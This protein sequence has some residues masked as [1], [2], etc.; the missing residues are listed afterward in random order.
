MLYVCTFLNHFPKSNQFFKLKKKKREKVIFPLT[1]TSAFKQKALNWAENHAKVVCYFDNNGYTEGSVASEF[2]GLLAI[3]TE[4]EIFNTSDASN[5]KRLQ[6]LHDD[7][8]NWLFGFL[9]YDLKNEIERLESTHFDGVHFP[10]MHF[11]EPQILLKISSKSVEFLKNTEGSSFKEILQ[12]IDN[13]E[14]TQ[15]ETLNLTIESRFSKEAYIATVERIKQHIHRGDIFEMNFCQE[16]FV[17][18]AELNQ[19]AL[20]HA[21]NGL[22]QT[23]FAAFYKLNDTYIMCASPERFLKKTGQKLTSQ[24]IKGTSKRGNTEGEDLNLKQALREDPKNRSENVMIVDLVRNDLGKISETGTVEVTEL[25]GIYSFPTVH[26][27]ISTVESTLKK[28]LPFTEALRQTFPMGSMTG[29][30]KVRA[31]QLIEQ[32][33]RTRRGVYSGA[34]GYITPEGDFDFNVVIRSIL[35]NSH[36][37]YVSFQV[38]GAIIAESDAEKEYAECQ[39]KAANMWRV[40]AGKTTI[41]ETG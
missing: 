25:F 30:P 8:K 16:F 28:D 29:A 5:F 23:P 40:L 13:Q 18:D 22:S 39:I 21:L 36:Q 38:G 34:I 32:Y 31:M 27:M 12:T 11:F 2:E 17:N 35:Y 10:D 26:Q 9:S 14:L 6:N 15:Q 41:H 1:D 7:R 24:P 4:T 20:F 19:T 3:G 37:K 33:E